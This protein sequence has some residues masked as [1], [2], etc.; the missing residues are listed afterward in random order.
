VGVPLSL[1]PHP[2]MPLPVQP[3]V[4]TVPIRKVLE[5]QLGFANM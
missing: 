2:V 5:K 4:S 1:L 3:I